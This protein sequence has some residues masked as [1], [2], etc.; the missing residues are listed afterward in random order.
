MEANKAYENDQLWKNVTWLFKQNG[1]K[2]QRIY[3]FFGRNASSNVVFVCRQENV[4]PVRSLHAKIV[5]FGNNTW[6]KS[7]H[8]SAQLS[9]C[10]S[11]IENNIHFSVSGDKIQFGSFYR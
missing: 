1:F 9:H 11:I 4:M 7:D 5:I 2:Y 8:F 3:N 10:F 6:V